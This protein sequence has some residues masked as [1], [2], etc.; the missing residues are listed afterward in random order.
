MKEDMYKNIEMRMVQ[1]NYY[2][3][4]ELKDQKISQRNPWFSELKIIT[5]ILELEICTKMFN[6][7]LRKETIRKEIV[8]PSLYLN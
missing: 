7:Q 6:A 5:E 1:E 8:L 4:D 3:L 2:I